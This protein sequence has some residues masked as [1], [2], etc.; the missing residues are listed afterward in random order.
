MRT[1]LV[2][3][4]VVIGSVLFHLFSPWWSMPIASNWHYIDTTVS[5]TFWIT[6][7]VFVAV[8]LFMAYCVYRFRHQE[9]RRA[10]YEPENQ[11]L[12]LW[13][14]VVTALGV[15]ALLAPGL[16]VWGDFVSP[17]PNATELEAVGRQWQWNFRLPG[18]DGKLGIS[19][20]R[21]ITSENP[22]GISPHDPNGK[23]DIVIDDSEIHVPL[24]K[25]IRLVLRAIDVVHDFW[26]PEIRAKMDM[27]PGMVTYFW[28]TPEKLGT[29]EILCAGLCGV[30]HPSMRGKVVV[31]SESD[32]QAWLGKQKTF[33]ELSA[34]IKKAELGN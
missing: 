29:Y 18:K 30:G 17:P 28:F 34:P 14:T 27:V 12:E 1:A 25:P 6:G 8:I 31:D 15:A 2:L 19:D 26:V 3:V 4:A 9:G 20:A 23:D 33:A 7:A 22:M 11:K 13:L 10:A 21:F 5:L 32:Y 16:Y 24:G